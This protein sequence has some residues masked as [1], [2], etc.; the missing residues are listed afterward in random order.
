MYVCVYAC[1]CAALPRCVEVLYVDIYRQTRILYE[2]YMPLLGCVVACSVCVFLQCVRECVSV[3]VSLSLSL[4]VVYI[5]PTLYVC[6]FRHVHIMYVLF[7]VMM[8]V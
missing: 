2:L 7:H 6:T 4:C 5:Y 8:C 3:T 1:W